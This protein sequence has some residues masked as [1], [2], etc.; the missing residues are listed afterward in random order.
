LSC[1]NRL[2]LRIGNLQIIAKLFEPFID[3]TWESAR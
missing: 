2:F 3:R 1:R